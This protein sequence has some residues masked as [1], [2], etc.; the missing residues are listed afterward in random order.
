MDPDQII[1]QLQAGNFGQAPGASTTP[2]ANVYLGRT[3][4]VDSKF[5]GKAVANDGVASDRIENQDPR[6]DVADT[7][8]ASARIY[9]WDD[10]T[11]KKWEKLLL[12]NGIIEP[13]SYNYEDLVSAWQKAVEGASNLYAAG[14]NVT[15]QEYV[16]TYVGSKFSGGG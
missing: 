15:P 10:A 3:G 4:G 1:A 2:V 14:K 8:T 5:D 11:L 7:D 16:D 12:D 9:S 6:D 13:G